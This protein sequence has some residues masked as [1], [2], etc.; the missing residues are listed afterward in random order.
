MFWKILCVAKVDIYS[1]DSLWEP[2]VLHLNTICISS[3]LK[4]YGCDYDWKC[5]LSFLYR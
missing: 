5:V 2:I 1:L 3:A 4:V